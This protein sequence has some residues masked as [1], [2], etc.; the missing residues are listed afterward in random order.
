MVITLV[1][2]KTDLDSRR[3]VS[4]E[5]GQRFAKENNLIFLEASAKTNSFVEEAFENTAKSIFNKVKEGTLDIS[6]ETCG[7]RMGPSAV[8]ITREP[9]RQGKDCC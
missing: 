8:S 6:S 3:T 5:E 9:P 7:V 2:N 4:V 1:G